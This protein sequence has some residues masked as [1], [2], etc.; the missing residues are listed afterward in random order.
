MVADVEVPAE[1][2]HQREAS[3][4]SHVERDRDGAAQSDWTV[5]CGAW[6]VRVPTGTR[7]RFWSNP[8]LAATP[9]SL[10]VLRGAVHVGLPGRLEEARVDE[11]QQALLS[12]DAPVVK[13]GVEWPAWRADLCDEKELA[14]FLNGV[15][16]I[17]ACHPRGLLLELGYGYGQSKRT[18]DW[19]GEKEGQALAD[20]GGVLR[21]PHRTRFVLKVPLGA[22]LTVEATV[23]ANVPRE[24]AWGL[25][26][27][28]GEAGSLALDMG[29]EAVLSVQG[30][31]VPRVVRLGYRAAPQMAER[32][33]VEV[34]EDGEGSALLAC[35]TEKAQPLPVPAKMLEAGEVRIEA[36]G[37]GLVL[38]GL[39]LQG[40]VPREWL[41]NKL[42]NIP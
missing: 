3:G 22:P 7:V 34:R 42:K 32:V 29:N 1:V 41:L 28:N 27:L 12:G 18:G 31:P 8:E 14:G 10:Q 2:H 16:K 6:R 26:L 17:V 30:K 35:G 23:S 15:A 19:R 37:E 39:L 36:L 4:S 13:A 38:D 11:G 5:E 21:L 9:P 40:V 24:C 25:S 33:R 20:D